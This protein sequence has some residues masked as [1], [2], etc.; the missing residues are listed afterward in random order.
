MYELLQA[1]AVR[2]N[3]RDA[4]VL[5]YAALV[6]GQRSVPLL[7]SLRKPRM[8]YLG[9]QKGVEQQRLD[10]LATRLKN[11]GALAAIDLPPE[12]LTFR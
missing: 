9:W 2:R 8:R 5:I 1:A 10:W 6:G 4:R 7:E 11:G 12:K 3:G